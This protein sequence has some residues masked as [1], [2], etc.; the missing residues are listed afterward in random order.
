[1]TA[2][3]Q[4]VTTYVL[5][6]RRRTM[7]LDIPEISDETER[8]AI[9]NSISD[10]IQRFYAKGLA[11]PLLGPVFSAIPDLP[12]HLDIIKNF[13][14]RSLLGTDRYQGHP[15][16]VYTSLRI[17]PDIFSAGWICLSTAPAK[18][19]QTRRLNRPSRK[20]AIWHNVSRQDYFPSSEPMGNRPVTAPLK[21]LQQPGIPRGPVPPDMDEPGGIDFVFT[22]RQP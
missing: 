13:W 8:A 2:S 1:M 5:A 18:R 19:C 7:Q 22:R 9:E 15:Y 10:C 12:G 4:F 17:E 3:V 16:P 21:W 14:S 6:H 20:R 11:D